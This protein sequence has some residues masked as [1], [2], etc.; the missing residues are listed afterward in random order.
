MLFFFFLFFFLGL[1]LWHIEILRLGVES[2]LLLPG[3]T[4]ATATAI[5]DPSHICDLHHSSGQHQIL[6]SLSEARDQ[7]HILIDASWVLNL[8]SHI[9]NSLEYVILKRYVVE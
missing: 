2:G 5:P 1:H 4:T 3:Y 8:P 9:G 6:N 7:T